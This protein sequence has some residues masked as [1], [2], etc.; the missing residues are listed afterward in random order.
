MYD[1]NSNGWTSTENKDYCLCETVDEYGNGHNPELKYLAYELRN[2]IK[3]LLNGPDIEDPDNMLL[4]NVD[5][6]L[7]YQKAAEN[8][9]NIFMGDNHFMI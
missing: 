9:I 5:N 3:M 4:E 2:S 1:P 8:L 6:A 7:Y